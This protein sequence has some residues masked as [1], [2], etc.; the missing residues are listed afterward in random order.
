[1]SNT[2]RKSSTMKREDLLKL[3]RYYKGTSNKQQEDQFETYE[4]VW[5]EM[6]L[7]DH[8]ALKEYMRDFR[9]VFSEND[10][11]TRFDIPTTLKA[12]L[13]NRF[14]HWVGNNPSE[15]IEYLERYVNGKK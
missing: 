13:W 10:P 8:I 2:T 15:F 3:C 9:R 12:V 6:T 4:R 1:M 5:V 7:D 14:E 11:T